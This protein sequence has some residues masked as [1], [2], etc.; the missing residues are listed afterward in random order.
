MC[1]AR[2]LNPVCAVILGVCSAQTVPLHYRGL[3]MN[4]YCFNSAEWGSRMHE[5][6]RQIVGVLHEC[7]ASMCAV[8]NPA[9][10]VRE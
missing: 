1:P 2:D 3:R 7:T 6:Q 9:L 10:R 5:Y 4:I 8:L